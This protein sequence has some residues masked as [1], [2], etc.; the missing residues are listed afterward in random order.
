VEFSTFFANVSIY[1]VRP[2]A[3]NFA[4]PNGPMCRSAVSNFTYIGAMGLPT[5]RK[6]WF[7]ASE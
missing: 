1:D 7:S 5:W 6:C 2:L 3:L 4:Q